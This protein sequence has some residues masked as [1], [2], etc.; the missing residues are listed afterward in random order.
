[1]FGLIYGAIVGIANLGSRIIDKNNDRCGKERGLYR[2]SQGQNSENVYFD[3]RGR[4]KDLQ[5]DADRSI[6]RV[7]GDI[8]LYDSKGKMLRNL[9]EEQRKKDYEQRKKD[10]PSNVR[11][12][13][14]ETW[15]YSNSPLRKGAC[16]ITGDIF[17]DNI[18]GEKYLKRHITWNP[19]DLSEDYTWTVGEFC[20]ADF[21]M[22]VKNAELVDI[23]DDWKSRVSIT[24]DEMKQIQIFIKHFNEQ[25]KNGGWTWLARR[26]N[27]DWFYMQGRR[28]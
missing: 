19:N 13:Y 8:I 27:Y 9:S 14:Y 15:T 11:A 21:Y 24:E 28:S 20:G 12:C 23:T 18:T 4:M 2:L 17:L 25:Q 16:R 6:W 5:T 7:N 1:M 22:K 26:G 10:A 3:H